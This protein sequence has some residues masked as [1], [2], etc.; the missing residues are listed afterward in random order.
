NSTVFG[1]VTLPYSLKFQTSF[2]YIRMNQG[3]KFNTRTLDAF[4]FR[5]GEW[6]YF[7]QDLDRL[8]L[9]VRNEN[10]RRWTFL[11]TLTW[12]GKIAQKHEISSML[13][14]EAR[15]NNTDNAFAEKNGF[16]SDQIVE[17][18]TVSNMVAITGTQTDVA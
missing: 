10:L 11:N 4:S 3:Y 5:T 9:S 8:L 2:N 1:D 17:L 13:G 18:N 12:N 15:Y 14:Y 16:L 6:I 7:Y